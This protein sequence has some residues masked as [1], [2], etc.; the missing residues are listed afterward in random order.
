L[1]SSFN[2]QKGKREKVE[3]K[4]LHHIQYGT[5][6]I[7]LSY[8]EQ[9][10]DPSQTRAIAYMIKWLARHQFN[11]HKTLRQAIEHLYQQVEKN[12]LDTISPFKGEH[13]GD[14]AMPRP[15]ELAQAINRMRSLQIR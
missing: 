7:D 4:G 13:P 5:E 3:A 1:P 10:V 12:G 8:A 14:L 2:A 15:F 11:G 6:I 9:L